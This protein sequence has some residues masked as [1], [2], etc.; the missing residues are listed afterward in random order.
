MNISSEA[1]NFIKKGLVKN[2]DI[3]PN[4]KGL[5][6]HEWFSE[7]WVD[8]RT[9]C[10]DHDKEERTAKQLRETAQAIRTGRKIHQ[11][12]MNNILR[13]IVN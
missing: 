10:R 4:C 1:K 8:P 2:P 11:S 13:V 3:R 12:Q 9:K 5:L 7:S 6:N